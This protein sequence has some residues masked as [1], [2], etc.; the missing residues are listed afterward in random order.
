MTDGQV[1]TFPQVHGIGHRSDDKGMVFLR[2]DEEEWKAFQ[3]NRYGD[4]TEQ[5]IEAGAKA[6][7]DYLV[8]LA[9]GTDP[10]D[11]AGP[12]IEYARTLTRAALA[13]VSRKRL[14]TPTA[15]PDDGRT[16]EELAKETGQ[17]SDSSSD[18]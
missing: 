13:G 14:W 16:P 4:F 3:A 17:P 7:E 18:V 5:D 10:N 8:Q 2:V 15:K 12:T 9:I 11:E 1:A 6:M